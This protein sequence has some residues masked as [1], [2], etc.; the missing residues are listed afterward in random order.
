MTLSIIMFIAYAADAVYAI[1]FFRAENKK[2]A[3]S[4]GRN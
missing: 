1:P 3:A 4:P 2:A